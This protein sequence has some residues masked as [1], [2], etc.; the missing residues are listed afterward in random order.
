MRPIEPIKTTEEPEAE[1]K[2][3]S[4]TEGAAA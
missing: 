3:D 4:H 1:A 2:A